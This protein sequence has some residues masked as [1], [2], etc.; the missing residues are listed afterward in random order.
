LGTIRSLGYKEED[1]DEKL[2]FVPNGNNFRLE[3]GA[4]LDEDKEE[5][6]DC[7]ELNGGS[8]SLSSYSTAAQRHYIEYWGNLPLNWG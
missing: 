8:Q 5:D 6:E 1:S 7:E 4:K 3:L 2:K